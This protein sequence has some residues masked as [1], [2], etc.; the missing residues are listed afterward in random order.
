MTVPA[1]TPVTTPVDDPTVAVA[2][3]PLLQVPP[4]EV[5]VKVVVLPTHTDGVPELERLNEQVAQLI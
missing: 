5:V 2:V 1:A 4:V 3:L